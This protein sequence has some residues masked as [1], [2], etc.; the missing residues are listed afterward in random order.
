[1]AERVRQEFLHAW[2]GYKQYAWGMIS[3]SLEQDLQGL[4]WRV[5]VHDSV[6]AMDTHVP[7]GPQ[8]GRRCHKGI[9]DRT[10]EIRSTFLLRI[11]RL[12]SDPGR[13]TQHVSNHGRF[14]FATMAEDR[15]SAPSAFDSPTG[16]PYMYVN[17]KR[18]DAR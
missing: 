1:M 12:Q 10:P 5:A 2:N 7:D 11:L 9:R 13:L 16:L 14:A 18:E 17:L 6:D 15:K 4:V 8:E 3:C